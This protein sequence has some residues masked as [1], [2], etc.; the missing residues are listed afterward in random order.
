[1]AR[2]RWQPGSDVHSNVRR[3]VSGVFGVPEGDLTPDTHFIYDLDES[4][5]MAETVME[6]EQFFGLRIP[7]AEAETLETVGQLANYIER[8]LQSDAEG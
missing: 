3:I 7:D 2:P 5:E 1:M 8:R 6:C 4:L